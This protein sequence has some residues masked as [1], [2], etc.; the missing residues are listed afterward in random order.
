[1]GEENH[2]GE[3]NKMLL[4]LIFTTNKKDKPKH[5][6]KWAYC[7][8]PIISPQTLF[9]RYSKHKT[10]NTYSAENIFQNIGI[11]DGNNWTS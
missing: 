11:F 4:K 7:P 2:Y 6:L 9:S 1:M 10:R 5:L 8:H 3:E